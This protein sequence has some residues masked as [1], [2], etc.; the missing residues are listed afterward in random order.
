MKKCFTI[1]STLF[2]FLSS[3]AFADFEKNTQLVENL[4]QN[5]VRI[6]ALCNFEGTNNVLGIVTSSRSPGYEL[7]NLGLA[8]LNDVTPL[9]ISQNIDTIYSSPAFR[10]QQ[11]ANLLGKAFGFSPDQMIL[12]S[13]LEMQN[14]GS[15]EG[16]DYDLYKQLFTSEADM[17]QSTPPNGEPGSNVFARVEAF[18][19][20]LQYREN[21]TFLVITHAFNFCHIS[22]C[23]TGKFGN[24]PS[25][26]TI[27]IYDFQP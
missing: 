18:L 10:V 23:L 19:E 20:T 17:L 3:A 16:L 13:R 11:S 8:K 21:Q 27:V 2:V 5:N 25:P 9:L 7:T 26:G 15:A 12:D 22:K 24:V 1:L 4:K 14:F 6:V